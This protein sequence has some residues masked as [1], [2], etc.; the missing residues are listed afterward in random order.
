MILGLYWM[1]YYIPH[2]IVAATIQVSGLIVP[3]LKLKR[4][5]GR[6]TELFTQKLGSAYPGLVF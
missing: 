4:S 1:L 2:L 6:G 3:I 5:W